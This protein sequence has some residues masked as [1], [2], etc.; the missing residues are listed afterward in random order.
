MFER[1]PAMSELLRVVHKRS[2]RASPKTRRDGVL[3]LIRILAEL[4]VVQSAGYKSLNA[5][6]LVRFKVLVQVWTFGF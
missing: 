2:T 1:R 4:P 6:E 5:F 3:V